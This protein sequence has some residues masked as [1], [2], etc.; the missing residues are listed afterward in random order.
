MNEE[1]GI[2]REATYDSQELKWKLRRLDSEAL[3]NR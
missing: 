3:E 2:M 1:K